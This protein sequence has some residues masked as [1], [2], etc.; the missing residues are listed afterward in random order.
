MILGITKNKFWRDKWG[1]KR[2]EEKRREEKRREEK[3]REEKRREEKRREE[4][5]REEKRREEKRREEKII[6]FLVLV[7]GIYCVI[8]ALFGL[9]L[10]NF[11]CTTK[12]SL[13]ISGINESLMPFLVD[14]S[15]SGD[16][17]N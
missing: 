2:R 8:Q 1:E 11:F 6:F 16:L 12:A 7:G 17:I 13:N 14:D 10:L 9:C 15:L 5:R 4:K 3:R